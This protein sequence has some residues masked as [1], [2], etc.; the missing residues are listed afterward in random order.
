M[1]GAG[2]GWSRAGL[3][4]T[5]GTTYR[6]SVVIEIHKDAAGRGDGYINA[7]NIESGIS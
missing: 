7:V 2:R 6:L 5:P 1:I 4:A 3:P